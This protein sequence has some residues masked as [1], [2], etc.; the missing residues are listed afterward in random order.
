MPT[1]FSGKQLLASMTQ[2]QEKAASNIS[3]IREVLNPMLS[4]QGKSLDSEETFSAVL[5]I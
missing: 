1:E 4:A 3:D 5:R 2:L